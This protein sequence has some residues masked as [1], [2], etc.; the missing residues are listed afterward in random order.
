MF[1]FVTPTFAASS[2]EVYDE[3]SMGKEITFF[4]CEYSE[5]SSLGSSTATEESS[6]L[7]K[8]INNIL[9]RCPYLTHKQILKEMVFYDN[10]EKITGYKK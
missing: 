6:S 10:L 1:L 7:T 2:S 5:H 8:F 3:S 9:K 4:F